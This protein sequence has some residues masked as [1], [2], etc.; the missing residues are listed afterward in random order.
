[1]FAELVEIPL[2]TVLILFPVTSME[3]ALAVDEIPVEPVPLISLLRT[4]AVP[5][6]P[7]R[8]IPME[9]NVVI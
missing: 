2:V 9:L 4:Y 5:P 8:L 1:M 7:V 6:V 3:E